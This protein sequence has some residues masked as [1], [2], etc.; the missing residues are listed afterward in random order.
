MRSATITGVYFKGKS[1]SENTVTIMVIGAHPDDC[2][3]KIGGFLFKC[4]QQGHRVIMISMTSGNTGHYEMGGG[5]LA[6]RRRDE[7][8]ASAAVMG[9]ESRVL[10][11]PNNG[12]E[13]SL[14]LRYRLIELIR[15]YRADIVISHRTN[16][17]HPDHRYTGML[18]R[19]TSTAV[20]N[21][22]V[23]PVTD[24][25]ERN[26]LY[27]YLADRFKEPVPFRPDLVFSIDDVVETKTE[28]Y[29]CH[30]SQMYEWLPW[31]QGIIDEVPETE[32]ERKKWVWEW[33][34]SRDAGFAEDFRE[35]LAAK[36]GAEK[37]NTIEFAEAL[38]FSEYGSPYFRDKI[39]VLFPF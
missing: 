34:K 26:P 27:L 7:F 29:H 37:S 14:M 15:E 18:V 28:M 31:E 25:L 19:D 22:N 36:Y 8:A 32:A 17:Y 2:E 9:A 20:N 1:M 39:D 33:R 21:P 11:V 30:E 13:V 6:R 35:E 23:C 10:N 24:R 16:D 5:T 12:L 38:Q 3:V 4:C